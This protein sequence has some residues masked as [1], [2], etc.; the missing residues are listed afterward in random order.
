M[1]VSLEKQTKETIQKTYKKMCL[2]HLL[3][4]S[5]TVADNNNVM[6]SLLFA[7]DSCLAQYEYPSAHFIITMI[8]I[9]NGHDYCQLLPRD[10]GFREV[11][12]WS[13]CGHFGCLV[14]AFTTVVFVNCA[15]SWSGLWERYVAC[16]SN[17]SHFTV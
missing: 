16:G 11:M 1:T 8:L 3:V 6:I 15:G 17:K 7:H 2:W 12:E 4:Q 14:S 5:S 10:L 13:Q 9:D